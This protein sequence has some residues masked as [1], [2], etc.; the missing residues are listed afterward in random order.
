MKFSL[1]RTALVLATAPLLLLSACKSESAKSHQS[2]APPSSE[3]EKHT[4][5]HKKQEKKLEK[6]NGGA[7]PSGKKASKTPATPKPGQ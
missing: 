2:S 5:G 1:I 6:E 7:K 3:K 4:K